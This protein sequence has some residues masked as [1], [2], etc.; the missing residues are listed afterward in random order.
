MAERYYNEDKTT[1]E[2]VIMYPKP[3]KF[4]VLSYK[5]VKDRIKSFDMNKICNVWVFYTLNDKGKNLSTEF[6]LYD[7]FGILNDK[8]GEDAAFVERIS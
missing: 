4:R 5:E 8:C 3:E 6:S 2:K 1:I 7:L